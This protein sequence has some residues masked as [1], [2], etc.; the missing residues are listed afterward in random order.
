MPQTILRFQGLEQTPRANAKVINEHIMWLIF[1]E[2]Y[3]KLYIQISAVFFN[4]V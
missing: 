4:R 2:T 3:R 1:K